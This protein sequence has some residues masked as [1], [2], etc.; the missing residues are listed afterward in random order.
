MRITAAL[1]SSVLLAA[2]AANGAMAQ[3]VI[4]KDW[5]ALADV[6]PVSG[7]AGRT[8]LGPAPPPGQTLAL[9]PVFVSA[10]AG[11]AG[12][13]LALPAGVPIMVT[14]PPASAPEARQ[15]PAAPAPPSAPI[16]AE[17]ALQVI[18][19]ARDIPK[20]AVIQPGDLVLA[21]SA[22]RY[23]RAGTERPEDLIGLEVR[24]AMKASTPVRMSDLKTPAVIR[25]GD[26]VKL[27][28]STSGMR[29]AVDGLAQT[30]AARGEPV[31]VLNNYSKRAVDAI[32]ATSGEARVPALR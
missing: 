17:T 18:V 7:E 6:A 32:A 8:L 10:V 28:Y 4:S 27:V 22:S 14:R 2:M 5:I 11:Q 12:V 20:G 15:P 30:D 29:L 23:Q 16:A 9:D 25:K 3:V 24:R 1:V 31:R 19:L 13:I 26:R 21:P